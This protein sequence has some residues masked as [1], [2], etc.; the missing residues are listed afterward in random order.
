[1]QNQGAKRTKRCGGKE[2]KAIIQ[3]PL[4]ELF[5]SVGFHTTA[6]AASAWLSLPNIFCPWKGGGGWRPFIIFSPLEIPSSE[7]WTALNQTFS[8]NQSY[9]LL[10]LCLCLSVCVVS[11]FITNEICLLFHFNSFHQSRIKILRTQSTSISSPR[12]YHWLWN[13]LHISCNWTSKSEFHITPDAFSFCISKMLGFLFE[14]S[15]VL[16]TKPIIIL[17]TSSKTLGIHAQKL[18]FVF[19]YSMLFDRRVRSHWSH[20]NQCSVPHNC[21]QPLCCPNLLDAFWCIL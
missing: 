3:E 4:D 17:R 16:S 15:R 20:V 2:K 19:F 5:Y 11:A 18:K 1:M 9:Q 13:R 12:L 7:R 8:S 14:D 21:H 6:V 10:R